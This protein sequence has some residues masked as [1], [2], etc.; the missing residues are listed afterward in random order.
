[1]HR[2]VQ[3][4]VCLS[5]FVAATFHPTTA[6][7]KDWSNTVAAT[8]EGGFV[9]GNPAATTKLVEFVSMSCPHCATFDAEAHDKLLNDWVKPGRLSYEIRNMV[10]DPFDI[11]AALIARC[12]GPKRFFPLTHRLLA[13]QAEWIGKLT[14]LSE[15]D[16]QSLQ[17]MPPEQ[18]F[19]KIAQSA[20]LAQYAAA[21]GLKPAKLHRCLADPAGKDRLIQMYGAATE[22]YPIKGVPAFLVNGML[23]DGAT[24]ADLE[25]KLQP[26]ATEQLSEIIQR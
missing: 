10:R 5:L 23:V 24:W 13:N 18:Q 1:M 19:Q 14:A 21:E 3:L 12:G 4:A 2:L 25:P 9:M 15:A 7:A 11:T 6:L 8:P 26:A 20:G 22:S 17:A 16:L